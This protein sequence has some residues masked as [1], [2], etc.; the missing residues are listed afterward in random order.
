[1]G[2]WLELRH[3]RSLKTICETGSLVAAAE[4]LNL[5][6]SALSHQI[7]GLESR[8]GAEL[9]FR[10]SRPLRLA[11]AGQML[12]ELADRV[13]PEVETVEQRLN[14]LAAGQGGRLHLAIECHSC[15][16]WL[17]P[18]MERYRERWPEVEMDLS[19]GFNFHPLPALVR[20]DIDMVITSDPD[21]ALTGIH[22]SPLF[23]HEVQLAVPAG[24]TLAA[25]DHIEPE[26]LA[27]QTLI[28]YPVCRSRLDV[29]SR[30]LDP[31]GVAPAAVRT[32]ELSVMI[33]QLVASRRGVTAMP[34]WALEEHLARGQIQVCR[35]G[36]GGLWSTL[37]AAVREE[38]ATLPY[39]SG[40]IAAARRL[41]GETLRGIRPVSLP[42]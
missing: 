33:V 18:T 31:A 2:G 22:Y 13:L 25:Q 8:V 3:L 9:F 10:R 40:F 11:P 42:E 36:P 12:L 5:T 37:Y 15:Y 1:M 38:E 32:S 39:L 30:F 27:D 29:F 6:Q 41:T 28:T 16:Q 4:R 19:M 14:N 24:S 21:P 35:L 7:K 23:R 34:S 20:G 26:D 17:L